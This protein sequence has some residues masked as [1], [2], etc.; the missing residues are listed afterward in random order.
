MGDEMKKMKEI[1]GKFENLKIQE[2]QVRKPMRRK[3]KTSLGKQLNLAI[4]SGFAKG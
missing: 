4:K 3:I 1:K 2:M